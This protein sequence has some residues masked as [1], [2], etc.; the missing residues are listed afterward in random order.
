[1]QYSEVSLRRAAPGL[2]QGLQNTF[3][4]GAAVLEPGLTTP[5]HSALATAQQPA[6]GT[7]TALLMQGLPRP[8]PKVIAIASGKG[9]AGKTTVTVNLGTALAM[10]GKQTVLLDGDLSLANID[11]LL[12]LKPIHNLSH[13]LEGR[14]TLEDTV[15]Y[16]L[17]GLMVIPASSG[18]KKMAQLSR[19]ENV[20]I[21]HALSD[22]KPA[23]DVLLVDTG[24]GITDTVLTLCAASQEVILVATNDPASIT[25]AYALIKVLSSEHGVNRVQVL[26]N[27]VT[28]LAEARELHAGLERATEKF[29]NVTLG[30]LGAIPHDDWLKAAIRKQKPVV[31][32]YPSAP[33][34]RAFQA[35][36][37]RTDAWVPGLPRGR[38]EFFVDRL[39]QSPAGMAS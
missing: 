2:E 22:F 9:G 35:L 28:N 29:L 20:G 6:H 34:A 26:A 10:S 36:A 1:M 7:S 8:P 24:P 39:L 27:Q 30:F 38:V 15:V 13:V 21:V 3:L 17:H 31:D 37:R 23:V 12:G 32:L 11:V 19:A 25:N 14:C 33:S 4:N 18:N 5:M 16:G